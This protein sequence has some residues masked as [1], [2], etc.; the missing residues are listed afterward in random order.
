MEGFLNCERTLRD[1]SDKV[2]W[3]SQ[4]W[5]IAS[6]SNTKFRYLQ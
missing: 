2:S 1:Q 6:D 5:D 3:Q 4:G